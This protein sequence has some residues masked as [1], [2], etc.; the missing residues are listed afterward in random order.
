MR[1]REI[2]I[3]DTCVVRE[4]LDH[5]GN[6]YAATWYCE[7]ATRRVERNLPRQFDRNPDANFEASFWPSTTILSLH[8]EVFLQLPGKTRRTR[9]PHF[10]YQVIT[11]LRPDYDETDRA[12]EFDVVHAAFADATTAFLREMNGRIEAI[13]TDLSQPCHR[14]TTGRSFRKLPTDHNTFYTAIFE[15][16]TEVA[17]TLYA[18]R[19]RGLVDTLRP[20]A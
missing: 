19:P 12:Y 2:Q 15:P 10:L 8:A 16:L 1:K 4:C 13:E 20:H 17:E 9:A 14:I 11:M 6:M 3:W 5:V 7:P 18:R